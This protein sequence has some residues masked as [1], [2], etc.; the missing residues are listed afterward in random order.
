MGV[1]GYDVGVFTLHQD[2]G[3]EDPRAKR[4]QNGRASLA[5]SFPIGIRHENFSRV[6]T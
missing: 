2:P 1:S 4:K 3:V 6:K 5:L